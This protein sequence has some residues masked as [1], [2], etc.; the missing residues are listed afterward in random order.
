MDKYKV[1]N[2]VSNHA[3]DKR[4]NAV[5]FH[6]TLKNKRAINQLG[7]RLKTLIVVAMKYAM[8]MIIT[9]YKNTCD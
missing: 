1:L 6:F 8:T 7:T 3:T 2:L 4:Y 5:F 9:V